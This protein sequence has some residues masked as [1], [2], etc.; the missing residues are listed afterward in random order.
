MPTEISNALG[1]ARQFT[2]QPQS[3]YQG[4]Y[5]GVNPTRFQANTAREVQLAQSIQQLSNALLS[6]RVRHEEYK[7]KKGLAEA[8]R[9]V[10]GMS[11][12]DIQK[13]NLIEASQKYG[14]VDETANPYFKAYVDKLRGGF[15]ASRM[16]QEYDEYIKNNPPKTIEDSY[17]SWDSFSKAYIAQFKEDNPVENN[18]AFDMGYNE[19]NLVT[20]IQLTNQFIGKQRE[21][22]MEVAT[23]SFASKLSNLITQAPELLKVNGAFTESFQNAVNEARLANI[24]FSQMMEV[25]SKVLNQLITSGSMGV[26]RLM[27]MADNIVVSTQADGTPIML[28]SLIN[29]QSLKELQVEYDRTIAPI[30]ESKYIENLV[31][32]GQD[33]LIELE[34]TIEE[35]SKTDPTKLPYYIDIYKEVKRQVEI[36]EREQE[37][38]EK[39]LALASMQEQAELEAVR[40]QE[41]GL[42]SLI[43][44]LK[45]DGSIDEHKGFS[46]SKYR[47]IDKDMRLHFFQTFMRDNLELAKTNPK[48]AFA[49]ME[50]VSQS[51]VFSDLIEDHAESVLNHIKS[52]PPNE[53]GTPLVIPHA[54]VLLAYYRKNPASFERIFGDDAYDEFSLIDSITYN[55]DFTSYAKWNEEDPKVREEQQAKAKTE[56]GKN[57]PYWSVAVT[58]CQG[59]KTNV[60]IQL[61]KDNSYIMTRASNVVALGMMQG[62]EPKKAF[63][64]YISSNFIA[65]DS[66]GYHYSDSL[67]PKTFLCGYQPIA[68]QTAVES[69]LKLKGL[70]SEYGGYTIQYNGGRNFTVMTASGN[71]PLNVDKDI[72]PRMR[73]YTE[74]K[75]ANDAKM[76]AQRTENSIATS[77]AEDWVNSATTASQMRGGN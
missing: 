71:I 24:P 69:V 5:G 43:E 47:Q 7:D 25:Q 3:S 51:V 20:G 46:L 45:V 42:A 6:Y 66:S 72:V 60:D 32:K 4:N 40:K 63:E 18:T 44:V 1:T 54:Q 53:D 38:Y 56:V 21:K 55:N 8:E 16:K 58:D 48:K 23:A 41:E 22:D 31:T 76:E 59:D 61:F 12:E 11:P 35:I 62:V 77:P 26:E 73:E 37:R 74:N 30:K 67:I 17:K 64:K 57:I 29:E 14:Y 9:M 36:E 70:Y 10:N 13:L 39:Q 27:Q 49:Q 33:G 2:P 28:S 19:Q 65:I 68:F 75:K 52:Y 15:V 34:K 50:R